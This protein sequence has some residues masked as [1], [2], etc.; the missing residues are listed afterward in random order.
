MIAVRDEGDVVARCRALVDELRAAGVRA[1]LDDKTGG[2]LGRRVT[3]WEL[4]GVP[5]RLE[6]GPRDLADD[7]ATLAFRI[8]GRA[9]ASVALTA[10]VD[11]VRAE[12][13][14]EQSA[15][16]SRGDRPQA[17]RAPPTSPRSPTRVTPP[18]AVGHACR[19]R[20]SAPRVR[21]SSRR[22]A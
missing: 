16:L 15:L 22:A 6:I 18:R 3:D 11:T 13:E 7:A 1:E 5:L 4:K 2:S 19:G 10:V 9:K 8:S 21:P 12:L 14:A 17:S 20:P